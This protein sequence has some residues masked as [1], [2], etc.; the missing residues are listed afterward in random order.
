MKSKH[1]GSESRPSAENDEFAEIIE[2]LRRIHRDAAISVD[3]SQYI[4][5]GA[6]A[7]ACIRHLESMKQTIQELESHHVDTRH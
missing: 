1:S 6:L 3:E 5:L 4:H 7:E 2:T